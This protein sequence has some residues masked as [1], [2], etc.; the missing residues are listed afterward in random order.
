MSS[1]ATGF[2]TGFFNKLAGNIDQRSAD[3]REYF[4]KQVEV[5]RTVGLE[6]RQRSRAAADESISIAKRLQEMGV[7]KDII[8][9]QASMNPA[10]LGDFFSQVEKLRLEA[11]VPVDEDFF[12]SVYKLSGSFKAPDEDFTTFFTRMYEPIVTAATTD[13]EGFKQDK[14]GSIFAAAFGLNAMDKARRKLA[15]TEVAPGLTA[16]QAIAMGDT[17]KP[18][19]SGEAFVT[20]DPVAL[21]RAAGNSTLTPTVM[22]Q[23]REEF[24]SILDTTA[25]GLASD[26]DLEDPTQAQDLNTAATKLAYEKMV[27]LYAGNEDY[28]SYIRQRYDLDEE[29][30]TIETTTPAPEATG[31][32]VEAP[33]VTV[34]TEGSQERAEAP[35]APPTASTE[36]LT[37]DDLVQLEALGGS[38]LKINGDGTATFIGPD[39]EWHTYP[40]D[41]LK[42]YLN[43]P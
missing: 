23:V 20:V 11:N 34:P 21:K 42:A 31:E 36:A 41:E 4:N 30:N 27:E 3:A 7:P 2:A 29:G 19:V 10:G 35:V 12:R 1:F 25:T 16:E 37:N 24:E 32:P 8:M 6:N 15:T 40:I 18:N 5:A 26:Y 38:N 43:S 13:P 17:P 22:A 33:V 39:G 14:E 9:A 28:L